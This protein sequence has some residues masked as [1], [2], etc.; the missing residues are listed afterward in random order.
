MAARMSAES[1]FGPAKELAGT[2]AKLDSALDTRHLQPVVQSLA[3]AT[4][5]QVYPENTLA[6]IAGL[7]VRDSGAR[8]ELEAM[9]KNSGA[10][11]QKAAQQGAAEILVRHSSDTAD[12]PL[13]SP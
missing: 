6:A 10:L 1:D 12:C 13:E 9:A 11:Y 4:R 3:R 2:I 7:A 8:K 5:T